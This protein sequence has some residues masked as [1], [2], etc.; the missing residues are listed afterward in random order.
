MK[1]T[2]NNNLLHFVDNFL[3]RVFGGLKLGKGDH[4][5]MF[6]EKYFLLPPSSC[7]LIHLN[8]Q[9]MF[10]NQSKSFKIYAGFVCLITRKE[11]Q[12]VVY[13]LQ[14]VVRKH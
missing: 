9:Q 2:H 14:I 3:E 11:K 1:E 8:S 13:K 6:S 12:N 5:S 10:P 4:T 7:D